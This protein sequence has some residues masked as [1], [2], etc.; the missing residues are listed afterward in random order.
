[1]DRY[2]FL[3]FDGVINTRRHKMALYNNRQPLRDE[4]GP[5]FDPEAVENLREIVTTTNAGIIVTS[6]WRY[7]GIDA[8]HEL[9]VR[10]KMPGMLVDVTPSV[11]VAFLYTRG[12]EINTWL[13]SNAPDDPLGYRYTIIDDG[14]DFLPEQA[15]NL[16]TTNPEVG[17]TANDAEKAKALLK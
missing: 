15:D 5:F 16:V 13:A 1:M 3:D 4:Y 14:V 10:R 6:T 12:M 9:W 8:M 7:K 2:V 11:P 17:L